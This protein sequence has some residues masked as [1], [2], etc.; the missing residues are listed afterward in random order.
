MDREHKQNVTI[1][2]L[3]VVYTSGEC[4]IGKRGHDVGN[5]VCE[6]EQATCVAQVVVSEEFFQGQGG[7]GV[8]VEQ[9]SGAILHRDDDEGHMEQDTPLLMTIDGSFVQEDDD[10]HV[11]EVVG[12]SCDVGDDEWRRDVCTSKVETLECAPQQDYDNVHLGEVSL[13]SLAG[14]NV[15]KSWIP[16]IGTLMELNVSLGTTPQCIEE[17]TMEESIVE[18]SAVASMSQDTF[19]L[20][21]ILV[22]CC[23]CILLLL[24]NIAIDGDKEGMEILQVTI[25]KDG[26]Q[27]EIESVQRTIST[28]DNQQEI[29]IPIL[30]GT[31]STIGNQDRLEIL[32][33]CISSDGNKQGIEIPHV[34]IS[35]DGNQKE[36]ESRKSIVSTTGNQQEIEIPILQGTISI[37]QLGQT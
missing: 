23:T 31:I 34:T 9:V 2:N 10:V 35:T 30:Q 3:E 22:G 4:P 33:G 21:D 12:A 25:F 5:V 37:G 17:D 15:Q 16:P 8:D 24:S 1:D 28:I 36:I 27:H 18:G 20:D 14:G 26:N 7:D 29:E 13:A 19:A 11:K 6:E 32:Q